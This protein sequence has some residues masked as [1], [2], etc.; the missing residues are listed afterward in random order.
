LGIIISHL[1]VRVLGDGHPI[2]RFSKT[3]TASS[4][5]SANKI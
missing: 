2:Q 4:A 1:I 5:S 3:S